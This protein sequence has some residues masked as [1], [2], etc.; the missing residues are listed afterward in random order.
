[1]DDGN[2]IIQITEEQE[3]MIKGFQ[4][5]VNQAETHLQIALKTI[6]LGTPHRGDI[7]SVENKQLILKPK[8]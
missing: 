6:L 2:I 1:M 5:Q 3:R 7:I 8:K 4:A